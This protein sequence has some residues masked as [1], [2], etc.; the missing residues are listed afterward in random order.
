LKARIVRAVAAAGVEGIAEGSIDTG[1]GAESGIDHDTVAR[2]RRQLMV[3]NRI[4]RTSEG[5]L[6]MGK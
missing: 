3:E 4:R 6:V 5:R 2:A 1:I